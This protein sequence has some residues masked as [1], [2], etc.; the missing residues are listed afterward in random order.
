MELSEVDRGCAKFTATVGLK[1]P[2]DASQSS[3]QFIIELNFAVQ[4]DP[5]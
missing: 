1:M 2:G 5:P 3:R 4:P